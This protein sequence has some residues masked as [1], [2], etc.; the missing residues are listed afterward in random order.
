MVKSDTEKNDARPGKGR[1][2]FKHLAPSLPAF[3]TQFIF[4]FLLFAVLLLDL[5]TKQA[6]F[7]WLR[8]RGSV[9]VIDG[10]LQLV[11]AENTGAAF[12]IAAGRRWLLVA[13]SVI[14]LVVIFVVFIFSA[15]ESRLVHVGL[16]LFAGG[17]CGNLYDHVCRRL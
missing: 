13:A 14:A 15:K 12:G 5:W 2:F 1:F 16:G 17:V 3:K 11:M 4:W 6:V 10:F 9:P 7:S 8:Q